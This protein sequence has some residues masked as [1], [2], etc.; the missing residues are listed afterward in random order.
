MSEAYIDQFLV[1]LEMA[2]V[3]G[4]KKNM[5]AEIFV[6]EYLNGCLALLLHNIEDSEEAIFRINKFEVRIKTLNNDDDI[7]IICGCGR[8]WS[9]PKKDILDKHKEHMENSPVCA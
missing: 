9:G 3:A 1:N 5:K 6:R 7:Q 2:G 8:I 4:F